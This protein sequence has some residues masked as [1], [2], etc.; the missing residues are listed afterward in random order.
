M[1]TTDNDIDFT[2]EELTFESPAKAKFE[3]L[4]K[5]KS[6]FPKA[7][8]LYHHQLD[9]VKKAS[10]YKINQYRK[11]DSKRQ[12][13]SLALNLYKEESL[14]KPIENEHPSLLKQ[15]NDSASKIPAY[16]YF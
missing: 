14:F 6:Q 8:A 3:D 9:F 4:S 10:L 2:A 16:T 12:P 13:S 1:L 7:N 5:H 15:L 11:L